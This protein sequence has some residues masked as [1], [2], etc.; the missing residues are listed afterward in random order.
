MRRKAVRTAILLALLISAGAAAQYDYGECENA[1]SEAESAAS[2]LASDA[3]RLLS[4]AESE[5]FFDD[6]SSEY[7]SVSSSHSDFED[8]VSEVSDYCE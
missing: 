4:C 6:C 3:Q 2:Y 8:A 5:D 7:S 1:R